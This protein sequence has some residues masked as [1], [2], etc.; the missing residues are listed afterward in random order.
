[1]DPDLILPTMRADVEKQLDL[2]AKGKADYET[3]SFAFLMRFKNLFFQMKNQTLEVFRKKFHNFMQ[4]INL[5]DALFEG[6]KIEFFE[7]FRII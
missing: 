1:M 5:V 6:P 3:V 4:N 2:I 7:L